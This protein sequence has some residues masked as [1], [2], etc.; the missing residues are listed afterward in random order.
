MLLT[1]DM[2]RVAALAPY[3]M[4]EVPDGERYA[5]NC[6]CLNDKVVMAA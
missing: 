6:L 3:E 5:A 1:S 2:P 4:I